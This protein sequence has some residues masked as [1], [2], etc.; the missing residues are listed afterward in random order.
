[1]PDEFVH[2]R[3]LVDETAGNP[4]ELFQPA[5]SPCSAGR[6][7]ACCSKGAARWPATV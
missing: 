6:S 3:Y 2:V 4:I 5:P 1:M 7:P